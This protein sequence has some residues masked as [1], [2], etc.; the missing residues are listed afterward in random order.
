MTV[1]YGETHRYQV[2]ARDACPDP[3]P[4]EVRNL[5]SS[6]VAVT[7]STAPSVTGPSAVYDGSVAGDCT[8]RVSAL[9]QAECASLADVSILRDTTDPPT[10]VVA[11]GVTL[12]YDDTVVSNG[13]YFYRVRATDQAGNPGE[14]TTVQ[15]DVSN[16]AEVSLY[17]KVVADRSA[18]DPALVYL[19]PR[20]PVTDIGLQG[21]FYRRPFAPGETDA[22]VAGNGGL[23][24]YQVDTP[25]HSLR[26]RRQGADLVIS[27]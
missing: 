8:V 16:C 19:V 13:T 3:A 18:L 5:E 26:M 17:R 4:Q 14:S 23:S 7:D 9:V 21:T 1:G 12:P 11:S 6:D 22:G 24:I 20:D 15:A 10:T 25:T 2:L 27:F